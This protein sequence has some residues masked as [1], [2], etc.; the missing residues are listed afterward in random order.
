MSGLT[1]QESPGARVARLGLR[2][3]LQQRMLI[4]RAAEIT[5]KSITDFVLESACEAAES[6]LLNQRLFMV[7]ESS[8]KRFLEAL[9]EPAKVNPKLQKLLEE[10]APWE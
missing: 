9:E 10:K 3:T 7:D 5:H 8:Y 4:R 6:A 1:N 2:A